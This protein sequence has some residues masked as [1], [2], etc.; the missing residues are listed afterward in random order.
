MFSARRCRDS[1]QQPAEPHPA[2]DDAQLVAKMAAGGLRR[3][4]DRR[5]STQAV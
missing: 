4:A 1:L 5:L 3:V 2:G